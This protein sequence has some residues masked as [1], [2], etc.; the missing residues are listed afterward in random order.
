M[1]KSIHILGVVLFLGNIIVSGLW[2]LAAEKSKDFAVIKQSLKLINFTD[3]VFTVP[4]IILII[5]S[6]HP[7]ASKIGGI[8]AHPWIYHSYALMTVSILIWMIGL[9]PIQRKQYQLLKMDSIDSHLSPV[10]TKLTVWWTILGVV[11]TALPLIAM[12]LMVVR[13]D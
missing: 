2:R 13:P 8:G 6:G 7:L 3:L 1:I 10:F 9:L 12:V 11:A 4:G 5:G